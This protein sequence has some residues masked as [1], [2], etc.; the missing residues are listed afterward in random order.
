MKSL[1]KHTPYTHPDFKALKT[2]LKNVEE[3]T[4][5][6]DRGTK[7]AEVFFYLQ[8]VRKNNDPIN[9]HSTSQQKVFNEVLRINSQLTPS[10]K[11]FVQPHRRFFFLHL[12]T[13]YSFSHSFI[14]YVLSTS[15]LSLSLSSTGSFEKGQFGS[16]LPTPKK[17]QRQNISFFV[18][19]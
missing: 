5:V 16:N 11:D 18:M 7:D 15:L 10:Y 2:A 6:L 19:M 4:I 17:T 3:I 14:L 13:E 9:S 1:L 8:I 12:N